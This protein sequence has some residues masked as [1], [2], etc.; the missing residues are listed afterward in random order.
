MRF[1]DTAESA[2]MKTGSVGSATN[3]VMGFPIYQIW[4]VARLDESGDGSGG[5]YLDEWGSSRIGERGGLG[6]P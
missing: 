1:S 2:T 3:L 5:G 6:G 4:Y